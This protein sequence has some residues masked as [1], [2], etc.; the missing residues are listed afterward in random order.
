MDIQNLNYFLTVYNYRSF[1]K[2]AEILHISQSA[3]SRRIMALEEECGVQL[4]NRGSRYVELTPAGE[5]FVI[6][7]AKIVSRQEKL[8]QSLERFKAKGEH[9]IGYSSSIYIHGLLKVQALLHDFMPEE[10]L[11]YVDI[12]PQ[13]LL[14]SLLSG[15]IDLAY[16]M[17][18]EIDDVSGI[19]CVE[20]V[21]NDL[22]VIVP[23]GHRLWN[24]NYV[25]CAD[26]AGETFILP[27]K[28]TMQFATA[29]KLLDFI[30]SRICDIKNIIFTR[31]FDEA[32]VSICEGAGIGLNGIVSDETKPS[33]GFYKSLIIG[34]AQLSCVNLVLAYCDSNEKAAAF[35]HRLRGLLK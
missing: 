16:T 28:D 18:G 11:S 26:L 17:H 15:C 7:A 19:S 3:L 22:T 31:S 4:I 6:D 34:D 32:L 12:D 5:C 23:R 24:R 29:S 14:N 9:I 21:G 27:K 33:C 1:S 35:A 20:L 13:N 8:F 25:T 10:Q 2:A 30:N